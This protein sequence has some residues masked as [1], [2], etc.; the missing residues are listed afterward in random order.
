M[1]NRET[2]FINVVLG[3]EDRQGCRRLPGM[4]KTVRD[5]KDRQG[6]QTPEGMVKIIG[7]ASSIG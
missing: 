7:H 6:Y 2:D 3:C 4:T 1:I 5:V